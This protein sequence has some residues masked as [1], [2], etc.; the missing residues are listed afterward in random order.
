MFARKQKKCF[1]AGSRLIWPWGCSQKGMKMDNSMKIRVA[2]GLC[3][4]LGTGFISVQAADTPA[5]A[6]ARAA[7]EPMLAQPGNSQVRS[8]PATNTLS[9]AAVEQPAQ[10]ATTVT[11]PIPE[12]AVT[13]Q[14]APVATTPVAAPAA[15]SPV[16]VAPA[17]VAFTTPFLLLSLL[18]LSLLLVLLLIMGLLMMKLRTLKLMLLKHPA[19][20]ASGKFQPAAAPSMPKPTPAPVATKRPVQRRKQVHP[21]NGAES[22]GH[23]P[24]NGWANTK[25]ERRESRIK[26]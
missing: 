26:G 18:F 20:V 11:G 10:S 2:L 15:V 19:I 6:A 23:P 8:L 14:I 25:T 12:K 1:A 7:L 3:V 16:A 4:V 13:P 5:Q 22:N 17:P 24:K 9:K 21:Q